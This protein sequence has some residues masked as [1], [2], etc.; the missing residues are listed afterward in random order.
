MP[1]QTLAPAEQKFASDRV[2][3]DSYSNLRRQIRTGDLLFAAGNYPVSRMIEHFSNSMFSHVGFLFRWNDRVLLLESV[4]D[5]GV[6]AVPLSQYVSDYENS[7]E[8]YDGRLFLARYNGDID[9]QKVT[10]MLGEAADL[11]NRKYNK[12]E[13]GMILARLTIGFGHPVEN[14]TY[15]CSEFVDEC[16]RKIDI[17][18]PR[19]ESGFIFPEQIAADP[20]V[21]PMYEIALSTQD[22]ASTHLGGMNMIG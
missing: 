16:F 5:D 3:R 7:G 13:V 15:I 22:V 9:A 11:L 10:A 20:R 8:P 12:E 19:A 17:V 6:R 18:F 14:N 21:Q 4:E 2:T 1:I